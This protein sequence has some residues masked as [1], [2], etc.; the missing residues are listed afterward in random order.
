MEKFDWSDLAFADKS[1]I[2]KLKA[3]FIIAP[4]QISQ[5]R[6][7]QLLKENLNEANILL[8]ISKEPYVLGLE[9]QLH[10]T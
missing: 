8:G 5:N 2:K 1:A 3:T 4:R 6:F 7:K 10:F 9:G